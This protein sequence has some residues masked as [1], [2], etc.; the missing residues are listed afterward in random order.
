MNVEIGGV[1]KPW[2]VALAVT[3]QVDGDGSHFVGQCRR[4]F[5]PHRFIARPAMHKKQRGITCAATRVVHFR[6][7]HIDEAR[8]ADD[9]PSAA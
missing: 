5:A 8:L 9:R 1:R 4:L 7:I 3:R 2:L 6:A